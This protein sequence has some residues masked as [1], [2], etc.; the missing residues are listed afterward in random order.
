[1]TMNEIMNAITTAFPQVDFIQI[2]NN[3]FVQF[4]EYESAINA[5]LDKYQHQ[6]MN[7]FAPFDHLERQGCCDN[8]H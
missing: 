4:T 6:V 1:M 2:D 3:E 7:D 8:R 5:F